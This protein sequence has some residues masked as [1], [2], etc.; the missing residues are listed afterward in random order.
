MTLQYEVTITG[1]VDPDRDEKLAGTFSGMPATYA[2][3]KDIARSNMRFHAVID[4][5][6]LLALFNMTDIEVTGRTKDA[7]ASSITF[8]ITYHRDRPSYLKVEDVNAPGTFLEGA[9][10][11]KRMIAKALSTDYNQN[12]SFWDPTVRVTRTNTNTT[13]QTTPPRGWAYEMVDATKL[14]SSI[15]AAEAAVTVTEL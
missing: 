11:V 2:G 3:S 9:D 15:S 14:Y 6:S 13:T 1:A 10:A 8:T 4:Q 7:A 5:L 12:Y